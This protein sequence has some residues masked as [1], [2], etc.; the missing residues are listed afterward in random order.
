M[1]IEVIIAIIIVVVCLVVGMSRVQGKKEE[2]GKKEEDKNNNKEEG[3]IGTQLLDM[4]EIVCGTA[5]YNLPDYDVVV[6]SSGSSYTAFPIGRPPVVNIRAY[7]NNNNSMFDPDTIK[8]AFLHEIAHVLCPDC[9]HNHEFERIETHLLAVAC[10]L[11]YL[12]SSSVVSE[13]YPCKHNP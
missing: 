12:S 9:Q 1:V 4:A 10:R 13:D 6:K 2:E 8:L 5:G 3:D 7:H 11:Y